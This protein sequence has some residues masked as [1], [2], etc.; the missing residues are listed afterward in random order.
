MN[1]PVE[2]EFRVGVSDF[3]GIHYLK[4]VRFNN[5]SILDAP[6]R[7]STSGNLDILLSSNSG[8]VIGRV[9]DEQSKPVAGA[10]VVAIPNT[11]RERPD[12]FKRF[13]SE[14]GSTG[15]FVISGLAPGDYKLF[16][17]EDIEAN[18]FYDPEVLKK[19]EQRGTPLRIVEGSRE[20]LDIKVIPAEAAQ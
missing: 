3:S 20:T 9:L 14:T 13:G 15:R 4:E 1:A 7:M 5:V 11:S 18:S 10:V 8:Q 2:G 16:A 6:A 19:Y 12:R 17:W